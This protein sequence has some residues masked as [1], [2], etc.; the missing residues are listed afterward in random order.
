MGAQEV[1][2]LEPKTKGAGER[3]FSAEEEEGGSGKGHGAG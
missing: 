1:G 2:C 3:D